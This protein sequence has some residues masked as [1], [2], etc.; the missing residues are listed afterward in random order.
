HDANGQVVKAQREQVPILWKPRTTSQASPKSR[1]SP[2]CPGAFSNDSSSSDVGSSTSEVGFSRKWRAPP[3]GVRSTALCGV[4]ARSSVL[5]N[6]ELLRRAGADALGRVGVREPSF[7]DLEGTRKAVWVEVGSVCEWL[8]VMLCEP[9]ASATGDTSRKRPCECV[10]LDCSSTRKKSWLW[11]GS[12]WSRGS[13]VVMFSWPWPQ[14]SSA[15]GVACVGGAR[16][17][18]L[19]MMMWRSWMW[20][21]DEVDMEGMAKED[22]KMWDHH[23]W[24]DF[25]PSPCSIFRNS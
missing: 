21:G 5:A 15:T 20:T 22:I 12:V 10:V 9:S 25:T 24:S 6:T 4:S 8:W 23:L 17:L 3:N 19:G 2:P 11:V 7:P 14:V 13:G 18:V 16:A 1:S